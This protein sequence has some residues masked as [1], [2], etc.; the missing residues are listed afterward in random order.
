MKAVGIQHYRAQFAS[1][2]NFFPRITMQV[3]SISWS[4]KQKASGRAQSN[5]SA[6]IC[7]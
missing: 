3:Y 7:G 1:L 6:A 4:V 2:H 5:R